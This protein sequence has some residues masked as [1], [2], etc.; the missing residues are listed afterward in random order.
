MDR[1]IRERLPSNL[2]QLVEK[3][4]QNV[5]DNWRLLYQL[6]PNV[7]IYALGCYDSPLYDKIQKV[8]FL[9]EKIKDRSKKYTNKFVEVIKLY[10]YLL[11]QKSENYDF[12]HYIDI[13]FLKDYCAFMD[14][15]PNTRGNELIAN[16]ILEKI[17]ENIKSK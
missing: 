15:H 16:Q 10:N 2:V 6:N 17:F 8:I 1:K 9:Q 12:V 11:Q 7:Q 13:T 3:C 5:E 4:T 14:F